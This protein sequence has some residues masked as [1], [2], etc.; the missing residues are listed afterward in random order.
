V[1]FDTRYFWA[2]FT[3]KNPEFLKKLRT[4]FDSSKTV[5]ASA[6]SIYEVYKLTISQED[7]TVAEIRVNSIKKEFTI[8]DVDP[9]IAEEA[10]RISHRV[11]VPMAD[12]L[13][14][15]TARKL[16]VPCATDDPHFTEVKRI[17]VA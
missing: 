15:A 4:I 6:I 5:F 17:W 16:R 11:K 14:M 7:R 3:S 12:A 2:V 9:M 10:A 8:I 1:L 13:I